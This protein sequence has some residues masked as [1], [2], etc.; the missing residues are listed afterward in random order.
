MTDLAYSIDEACKTTKLG[1]TSLY[2]A[3]KTG[4]LKARKIRRRTLILHD[5]LIAFLKAL[6]ALATS[7]K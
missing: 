2:A 1:R 5:D 6:P 3:I 4:A 7:D